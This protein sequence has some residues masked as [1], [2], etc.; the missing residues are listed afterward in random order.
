M[1][2]TVVS[3]KGEGPVEIGKKMLVANNGDA[4]G[5][6]GGGALEY[7]AREYC[8]ELLFEGKSCL[9]KYVL[10]EG[11][12]IKDATTLPMIC[13]GV[14]E[15][16]FEYIGAK[17]YVVIFGGGHCGHALLKVLKTMPYHVTIVDD[18]KEVLDQIQGADRKVNMNYADFIDAE[19][20]VEGSYVIVSTP[21]HKYDYNVMHKV[22]E[23]NL[24]PKY[25]GMLCSREK[26][27]DFLG[28]TKEE[29]GEELDL[30]NFYSPIGLDT[31][32]GSPEE[33]AISIAAEMLAV[34][35]GKEGHKHLRN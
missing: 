8:K 27:K 32:G 26:L 34:E 15:L 24:K 7:S 25:I 17:A 16:F 14:V 18:R 33:I 30:T 29:F 35:Y 3:K 11:K 22:F 12:V 31:G 9:V 21:S 5:T 20:I 13:G 28:K 19:G 23:L 1:M 10:N 4:F 6:V 2:V